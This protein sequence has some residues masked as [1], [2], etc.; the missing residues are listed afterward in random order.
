MKYNVMF[1]DTAAN[2]LEILRWVF[3][4]KPYDLFISESPDDALSQMKETEFA[5]VLADQDMPEMSGTEFLRLVKTKSP[6]TVGMIMTGFIEPEIALN[7]ID[8][9][10]VYRFVT[11][12]WDKEDL[13][14]AVRSGIELYKMRLENSRYL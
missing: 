2:V 14:E 5:L 11:K 6:C 10:Y 12:P 9:G 4:D 7:A 13:K 8:R 1:V 3:K